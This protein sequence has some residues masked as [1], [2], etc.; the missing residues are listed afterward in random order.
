M[1]LCDLPDD[2]CADEFNA[3]THVIVGMRLV[4]HLRFDAWFRF[5]QTT[6]CS[7]FPDAMR[8]WLLR[9]H[10]QTAT[11]GR[12]GGGCMSMIGSRNRDGV[13]AILF[14]KLAPVGVCFGLGIAHR[15]LGKPAL[16]DV[17]LC[18][19]RAICLNDLIVTNVLYR[20]IR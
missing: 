11:D 16:I 18:I 6:Q 10:V 5:G 19:Y 13:D 17:T 9:V 1:Y 15:S 20:Y 8:E 3:S 4:S 12:H 2:S 14:Q 7:C